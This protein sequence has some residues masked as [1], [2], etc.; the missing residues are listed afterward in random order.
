MWEGAF[1]SFKTAFEVTEQTRDDISRHAALETSY[2][3]IFLASYLAEWDFVGTVL[4]TS[5]LRV[6]KK[7]GK[8]RKVLLSYD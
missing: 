1:V 4:E 3:A 5:T 2:Y 7:K 8:K 6:N